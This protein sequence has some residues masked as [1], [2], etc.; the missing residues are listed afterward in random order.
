MLVRVLITFLVCF[1]ICIFPPPLLVICLVAFDATARPEAVFNATFAKIQCAPHA[2]SNFRGLAWNV[3]GMIVTRADWLDLLLM[4]VVM[5][6][7]CAVIIAAL[8]L[9][10]QAVLTTVRLLFLL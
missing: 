10:I 6:S 2:M 3:C 8:L 7:R 4:T 1:G 5:G 9:P